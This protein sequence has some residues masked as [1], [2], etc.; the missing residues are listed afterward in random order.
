M[1]SFLLIS[2]VA[3]FLVVGV[4]LAWVMARRGHSAWTWGLVGAVLGPIAVILAVDAIRR[5]DPAP[6][7]VLAG[8]EAAGEINVVVGMDGSADSRSALAVARRL[9]GPRLGRL[10]VVRVVSYEAHETGAPVTEEDA[11]ALETRR[12]VEELGAPQAGVV[13]LHGRPAE[14]LTDFARGGGYDLLVIGS[15]GGG[16]SRALIGSV[17]AA[18]S[19]SSPVPVLMVSGKAAHLEARAS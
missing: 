7:T 4:V 18:L 17:A 19:A 6:T 16:A 8:E 2:A 3:A 9:V 5:E 12:W 15:R 10:T 13:L 11:A 14:A 1:N